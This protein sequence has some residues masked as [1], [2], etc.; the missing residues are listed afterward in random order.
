MSALQSVYE[1]NTPVV[2]DLTSEQLRGPAHPLGRFHGF[3]HDITL[4][5]ADPA[6]GKGAQFIVEI[7]PT[8]G[9][10]GIIEGMSVREYLDLP[11]KE[12]MWKWFRMICSAN[13]NMSQDQIRS[14]VTPGQPVPIASVIKRHAALQYDVAED[15]YT[16]KTTG[17][18][19]KTR[20]LTPFVPEVKA[21]GA[22]PSPSAGGFAGAGQQ[23]Q[24]QQQPAAGGFGAG[25][26]AAG[27]GG[28]FGGGAAQPGGFGGG[29]A[30]T[31]FGGG[32]GFGG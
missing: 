13:P 1:V 30:A 24:Q 12:S 29:G 5:P 28:G 17:E 7:R 8:P 16:D 32:G 2:L 18:T 9:Q 23:Q 21:A 19:K 11:S 22:T 25:A 4:Q 27:A 6:K 10:T 20:R 15:S 14:A 31:G 3:V 26:D